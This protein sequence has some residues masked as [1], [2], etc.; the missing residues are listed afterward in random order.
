MLL[1]ANIVI[2]LL[3]K[4]LSIPSTISHAL[5]YIPQLQNE[6]ERL[7][8][9]KE[10]ILS[11]ITKQSGDLPH[12]RRQSLREKSLATVSTSQIGDREVVIQIC[13]SSDMKKSPFS[14][15]LQN[16]EEEQL[17]IH[18]ASTFTSCENKAFYTLHV[19]VVH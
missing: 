6:V 3:Q 1:L 18:N 11:S 13:T 17:Q 16:L 14:Q 19:Q 8:Q 10:E 5:K 9:R 4:K 2:F 12:T 7:V 15:V